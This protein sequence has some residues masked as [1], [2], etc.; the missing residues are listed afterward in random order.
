MVAGD[1]RD[2]RER[3][4]AREDPL[5]QRRMGADDRPL[6]VGELVGLVEDAVG[7]RELAEVVEQAGAAEG[8]EVVG[9]EVEAG[10]EGDRDLGDALG[11]AARVP[12]LGVDDA[13]ERLG[14]AVEAVVVGDQHAVRGLDRRHGGAV[15]RGPERGVVLDR[16]ERVDQR[17]VEPR[18]AASAGDP[19]RAGAAVVLPEDLHRLR[20]AGSGRAARS[21][22]RSGRPAALLGRAPEM[23]RFAGRFDDVARRHVRAPRAAPDPRRNRC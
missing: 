1:P 10:A 21:P 5:G 18:P 12:R 23:R 13:R 14:D 22:R 7:D 11:V 9:V 6:L 4:D 3:G 17:G 2:R 19:Q 8:A 16:G 15:E 20:E